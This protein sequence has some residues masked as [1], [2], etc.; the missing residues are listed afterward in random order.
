MEYVPEFGRSVRIAE[1]ERPNASDEEETGQTVAYMDELADKDASDPAVIA[2]AAEALDDAGIDQTACAIDKANAVYW[3]LKKTIRYVP[4]PGTSPLVDQTLIAPTAILA[5]PEPIGD[6]PQY[7]MMAAAM[8]RVL[9][10]ACYFKTIA[11]EADFPDQYSHIYNVVEVGNGQFLPFDSSN[12]PEPGAEFRFPFKSRVWPRIAPDRCAPGKEKPMLRTQT[13]KNGWRSHQL[14][15]ALGDNSDDP[16]SYTI[17][18]SAGAAPDIVTGPVYMTP[19]G[20]T[21]YTPPS[22]AGASSSGFLSTLIN[23]ATALAVPVVKAATQQAPY[24]ITGP[25]GQAVLYNPNTGQAAT[26]LGS[27][28]SSPGLLLGAAV[29]IGL[30]LFAKK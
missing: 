3:W 1:F 22:S 19:S 28:T 6:C 9:C 27:L 10:V 30:L 23:D 18:P 16:G 15:G 13:Y 21:T 2:A 26:G 11:S 5:M 4:T 8:F 20:G 24:Y 12:G 25:N 29:F 14:R 17:D 7:S